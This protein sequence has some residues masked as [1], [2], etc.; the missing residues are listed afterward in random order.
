MTIVVI[1]GTPRKQG[2]TRV[3][4]K[5]V[6]ERLQAEL[7]DLSQLKLPLFD[8]ETEQDQHPAVQELRKTAEE[9]D[10]FVWVSPEYHNGMSGALKNALE[11]LGAGHFKRKPTLLLA[12]S[13]GGKGGMNA[14]NQMRTVGRGLNAMVIPDQMV[15]DPAD[16]SKHGVNAEGRLVR[17]LEEFQT[18]LFVKHAI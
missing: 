4:A 15:F 8:G 13:G 14:I 17:I 11:F 1:S 5:E 18:Y 6:A 10:A 9:A 12:V 7:V 16:F 2:R 3:A